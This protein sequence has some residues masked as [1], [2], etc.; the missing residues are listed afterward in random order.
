MAEPPITL[1]GADTAYTGHAGPL[2]LYRVSVKP[3]WI[4]YNG[5]MNEAYYVLVFGLTTDAF[6]DLIGMDAAYRERTHT[7][8]YTVEGHIAYLQEV[9]LGTSLRVHDHAG[10]IR[11]K[12]GSSVPSNDPGKRRGECSQPMNCWRSMSIREARR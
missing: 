7:S 4:D 11:R 5:H 8:L 10:R 9:P 12:A 1:T 6:L 3:E 2:D